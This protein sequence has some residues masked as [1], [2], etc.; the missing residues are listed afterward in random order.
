MTVQMAAMFSSIS[1]WVELDLNVGMRIIDSDSVVL[2]GGV[3]T[4]E[5]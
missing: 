2:S 3:L 5:G 4:L 1:L